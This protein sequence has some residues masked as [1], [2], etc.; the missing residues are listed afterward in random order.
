MKYW[1]LLFVGFLVLPFHTTNILY[2]QSETKEWNLSGLKFR[3]IGPA[4]TS[5]R[6]ADLAV[7][8][9]N[10]SEYYVA[11]A[12]GGVWKTTNHGVTY[13]SIFDNYGSHSIGCMT[14]DPSNA[15][16]VW[17]GTGENNNQRSVDYGDGIYKSM[18]GGK[19][20]KNMG[21]KSSEHIGKIIIHPD[22]SDIVYVAAIGPLWKEGGD[23]GVY[24]STDGGRNWSRVLFI[25]E[26]TGVNDIVMDPRDPET[27]YA[28][29]FQRRRHVYTYLGGGPK[30]GIYKTTDG[31]KNW[32][33]L[34]SGLPTVD[35]GRI[36]LAIPPSAP[37]RVYAIVEAA[38]GQ[39]GF[40]VSRDNGHSWQKRSKY[41][42]SGNYYQEIYVDPTNPDRIFGMDTWLHSSE[43]GGR[44]FHKVNE[45]Y[46]HVDN[47]CMWINPSNP[48]NWLVGCDG[49]V[50]ETWDNGKSWDF[51]S[52]LPVTQFYKLGLDNDY[53]FYKVYG[54]TQDN[55]SLG[56]PTRSRTAHGILNQEWFIVH[57]G[58]GFQ[59]RVDPTN[60][61]IVYAS[62]QYGV[63][64]RFDRKTGEEVV[65]QPLPNRDEAQFKWNWDAP[66][67]I[68]H[69][70]PKR[71]YFAANKVFRS[72]DR[73]S[74]WTKIS[75]DLSAHIDRNK[76][77]V[78]GRIWSVDAV[79]KN[80]STSPYGEIVALDESPV[81]ENIIVAGTDDGEIWTTI[82]GGTN[83]QKAGPIPGAPIQSYINDL[84]LSQ[85]DKY[86]LYAVVNHHKYGDFKP[87]VFKSMDLGKTWIKITAGLSD[88]GS[89]FAI[90]EDH[91]DKNLLFCGTEFGVYYTS[92]SGMKWHPLK[93]GLP[94]ISIRDLEIQK[95][96]NDLVLASF[97]RGFFVL[98]DYSPLRHLKVASQDSFYLFKPRPSYQYEEDTPLGLPGKAFQGDGL[99]AGE[100]LGPV[101]LF[102]YS[103]KRGYTSLK[104]QRKKREEE[105]IKSWK[106]TPF[107]AYDAYK[108]E[109]EEVAPQL[110]AVVT[111]DLGGRIAKVPCNIT[112][113]VQRVRW[114]M[115]F[116]SKQA[117]SLRSY[118]KSNPFNPP[119][120]GHLV[121]A[122]L[123]HVQLFLLK[124]GHWRPVSQK[125]AF[126]V[127]RIDTP[128]IPIPDVQNSVQF[129]TDL[130][131]MVRM[132]GALTGKFKE[133]GQTMKYIS[134]ALDQGLVQDTSI[135]MRW[136]ALQKRQKD[137]QR[138]LY[139]D[140]LKRKLDLPTPMS[141]LQRLGMLRWG[142]GGYNGTPLT[143]H[144]Q[145]LEILKEQI[146]VLLSQVRAFGEEVNTLNSA[147]E[148]EKLP[149][150][151]GRN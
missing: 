21:L 28:A 123:Y 93:A 95:R 84:A 55:F 33:R 72:E 144:R 51:K 62:S 13:R 32:I 29:A 110:Y 65:I 3:S 90:V 54:G 71:L 34:T 40:F 8:L 60:P 85:H 92:D 36:G 116:P 45:R 141:P 94:T 87:Y 135:L 77:K 149:Y 130:A 119:P 146:P 58:D 22:N 57:G 68:S 142:Q 128:A 121:P 5:G 96:E 24:K 134:K 118:D 91:E 10:S 101:A 114:D 59:A 131:E 78:M 83:W 1:T 132:T 44:S 14:L 23:R 52:N 38:R 106:D 56:G 105:A 125:Q 111:D 109:V 74:S 113:G 107:P 126:E 49:G 4:I 124:E 2:A 108:N 6:I 25:D 79:A 67:I 88:R 81:D 82:D 20:F 26:H 86:T 48:D 47:H 76:L 133:A 11:S 19:S 104:A 37:D 73:G 43:D 137:L 9:D 16:T 17:V 42:T 18:D 103:V 64:V 7:N 30:S 39:G 97:G 148:K 120:R 136:S 147:L 41:N 70:D 122:G 61:N 99:Y 66:M 129:K 100:N 98:D 127:K 63:L 151:P 140:G 102:T 117:V 89:V 115:R 75:D 69:H 145:S 50:Y 143:T 53:P 138:A 112:K 46:K 27:L 12:A 139:G 80:R 15:N 150:T 31:G 35:L